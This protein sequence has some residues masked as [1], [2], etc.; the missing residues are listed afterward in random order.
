MK[1]ILKHF[2]NITI[3][4]L[5]GSFLITCVNTTATNETKVFPKW[6]DELIPFFDESSDSNIGIFYVDLGD[7]IESSRIF[8][9]PNNDGPSLI[10]NSTTTTLFPNMN[11]SSTFELVSISG[12]G[13]V[14]VGRCLSSS[15]MA[16]SSF[17]R[18]RIY[19][20][21]DSYEL[22]GRGVGSELTFTGGTMGSRIKYTLIAK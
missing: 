12:N 20:L 15:G 21:C 11:Y 18:G 16:R 5:F 13:G 10:V 22:I 8:S 14:I 17:T 7:G 1:N 9:T 2:L 3:V 19:T 6:P 4:V